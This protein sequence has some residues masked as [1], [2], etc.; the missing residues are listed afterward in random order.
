MRADS[1]ANFWTGVGTSRDKTEFGEFQLNAKLTDPELSALYHTDDL[2]RRV[3][4]I[5]PQEMLRQGFAVTCPDPKAAAAI[6]EKVKSLDVLNMVRDGFIWGRLFGGAVI[7]IG[8]DD[9]RDPREPLDEARIV[10][11]RFLQ[12]FDRRRVI[13]ESYYQDPRHPKFGEP[14]V[15]R[16]S[17]LR[18]GAVSYVHE[19]RLIVFRG[20]H[21]GA[22]ERLMLVGW[23]Y[24][25][26]Q[27]PYQAIRSFSMNHKAAE[28]MMTDASQAVFK[29]R[30]LLRMIAEN[31]LEDLQTRAQFLDMSRS[32]AR[33]IMIDSEQGEGIHEGRDVLCRGR[34]C[35]GSVRPALFRLREYPGRH[36]PGK[37]RVRAERHGGGTDPDLV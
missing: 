13:P 32:I 17:A 23:D 27:A 8:A 2:C 10:S 29:M 33:A 35:P 4:N 3:I 16:L 19:S 30:G 28:I 6:G 26:L 9:G 36:P 22:Q 11:L 25:V 31:K 24:S 37:G 1:W 15:Y 12:V 5:I 21:T 20:A 34:G 14:A 18:T 7:L